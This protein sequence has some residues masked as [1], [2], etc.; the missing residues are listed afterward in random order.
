MFLVE[1][2]LPDEALDSFTLC[3]E[4]LVT[5]R[6]NK[7]EYEEFKRNHQQDL[8]LNYMSTS[9]AYLEKGKV[10]SFLIIELEAA[11]INIK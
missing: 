9:K 8:I 10:I 11:Y 3:D 5:I 7:H 2:K 1:S 6:N 4:L